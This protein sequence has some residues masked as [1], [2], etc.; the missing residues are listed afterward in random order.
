M[1]TLVTILAILASAA[2]LGLVG[3]VAIVSPGLRREV[4]LGGGGW[5]V[6]ALVVIWTMWAAWQ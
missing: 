3:V 6:A 5:A 2:V 4:M 1:I